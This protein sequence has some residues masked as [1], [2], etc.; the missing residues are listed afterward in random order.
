MACVDATKIDE[1]SLIIKEDFNC[2]NTN[3]IIFHVI[4]GN[5]LV[6]QIILI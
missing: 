4:N 5:N 3:F 2:M 6:N 1:Y